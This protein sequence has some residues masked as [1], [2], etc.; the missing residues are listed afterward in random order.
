MSLCFSSPDMGC[1]EEAPL[2]FQET[3]RTV[4]MESLACQI[5]TGKPGVF[6][7]ASK[8]LRYLLHKAAPKAPSG[9][10]HRLLPLRSRYLSGMMPVRRNAEPWRYAMLPARKW[11]H[12]AFAQEIA[13]DRPLTAQE[14][15]EN[16][17]QAQ[18]LHLAACQAEQSAFE[19][20]EE[21][22]FTSH[23]LEVL[24]QS[25]RAVSYFQLRERVASLIRSRSRQYDQTPNIY[26]S[27]GAVSWRRRLFWVFN[28]AK[29]DLCGSHRWRNGHPYQSRA[30]PRHPH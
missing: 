30:H 18:H 20:G 9:G 22:I 13:S 14:L 15:E 23:L 11:E 24:R 17:P 12:F 5:A 6:G 10:Y 29:Q 27:Q 28:S 3:S 1:R 16:F 2:A 21:G 4:A 7:L 25:R 19:I 8:E 26:P